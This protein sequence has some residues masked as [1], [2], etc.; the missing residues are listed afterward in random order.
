M[1]RINRAG[2]ATLA[3]A[4][5]LGAA[6]TAAA[7]TSVQWWPNQ[8]GNTW[9]YE[10]SGSLSNGQEKTIRVSQRSG[11]WAYFDG[12]EGGT[13]LWMSS[14][15]GKIW[16]WN[17]STQRFTE[18]MDLG[19]GVRGAFQATSDDLACWNNMLVRVL[20]DAYTARTAA[21]IFNDCLVLQV[22]RPVCAD[23][24]FER[25][26]FAPQVGL[27]E[28]TTS[29]IAGSQTAR[30]SYARV[31]GVEHKPQVPATGGRL[32]TAFAIDKA[33]YGLSTQ[34]GQ[35]VPDTMRVAFDIEN[36]T[37][38]SV[39]YTY[40]SGMFYDWIVRNERG[41]EVYRWSHNRAFIKPIIMKTLLPNEKIEFVDSFE[42]R[43]NNGVPL[44]AGK[45]TVEAMH[46]GVNLEMRATAVFH[47]AQR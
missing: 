41:V 37:A 32:T 10:L 44:P 2:I 16:N 25:L 17:T 14:V 8:Q 29:S 7:Q 6:A 13:W 39:A 45:Y 22:E 15:S 35:L 4:L 12:F 3:L 5:T 34:S 27:V 31:N 11:G 43:D 26:V 20:D 36:K 42:L 47:I 19:V 28:Y 33:V 46:T 40:F 9:K 1:T 24:G 23:A 21:G 18:L 38:R 30:L